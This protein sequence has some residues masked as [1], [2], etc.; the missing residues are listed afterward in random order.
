M[1]AAMTSKRS[2]S[3]MT[4][5]PIIIGVVLL[6]LYW[7]KDAIIGG[8]PTGRSMGLAVDPVASSAT[9]VVTTGTTNSEGAG[10]AAGATASGASE[11]NPIHV[12]LSSENNVGGGSAS[13][14]MS[15]RP[16]GGHIWP[17]HACMHMCPVDACAC[18]SIESWA[19]A[20]LYPSS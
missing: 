11:Q 15:A 12:F 19:D 14:T 7:Q 9:A 4:M 8:A 18:M 2:S 13:N 5:M 1:D 17:V 10:G 20:F 6:V 3:R 16:H